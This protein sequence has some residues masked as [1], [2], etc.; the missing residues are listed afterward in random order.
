[1]SN[2]SRIILHIGTQKTGTTSV[3]HTFSANREQLSEQGFIYPVS[4]VCRP[5]MPQDGVMHLDTLLIAMEENVPDHVRRRLRSDVD[6]KKALEG[7]HRI[8]A[9]ASGTALVLSCEH[10]SNYCHPRHIVRL[11]DA[12]SPLA[13]RVEVL[14]VV[15]SQHEMVPSVWGQG[16]K[17]GATIPLAA[18]LAN[19]KWLRRFDRMQRIAPWGDVFGDTNVTMIPYCTDVIGSMFATIGV[20][21]GG[22]SSRYDQENR[23]LCA[24]AAE[25]MRRLNRLDLEEHLRR[26]LLALLLKIEGPRIG[27][28]LEQRTLLQDHFAASNAA[29]SERFGPIPL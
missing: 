26:E 24:P 10:L 4:Q 29:F 12:L 13:G 2:F 23:S 19:H 25:I 18:R 5:D 21:E 14:V 9:E 8:A 1:M 11:R 15:R 28:T 27:L 22:I 17:A 6:A 16:I 7:F 3:Q 20:A